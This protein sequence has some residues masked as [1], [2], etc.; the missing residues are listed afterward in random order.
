MT[1]PTDRSSMTAPADSSSVE[2]TPLPRSVVR[3]PERW[4]PGRVVALVA[5]SIL[6]LASVGLLAA[7]VAGIVLDQTQRDSSGYLMTSTTRYSTSTYALVSASYRGGTSGDVL[8]NRDLMGTVKVRVS[9]TRPVFIGIGPE[10]SVNTYLAGVA[11]ARGDSL[12][13]PSTDFRVHPGTAPT[14][15]PSTQPFW[16]ASTTGSGTQTV[17]W[18]PQPG[19]WRIVLMNADA[20]SGVRSDVSIGARFPHLLAIGIAA[21]G[22]ALVLLV[23]SGG[24]VYLAVRPRNAG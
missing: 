2:G 5:A 4:G 14:A 22:V 7:G 18:K 23:I 21:T 10:N 8:V 6:G 13:T 24:A 12:S 17:T 16:A 15:P 1:T 20:S 11:Y 9:S 3:Q 19:N